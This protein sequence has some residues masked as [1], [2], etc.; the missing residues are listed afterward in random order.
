MSIQKSAQQLYQSSFNSLLGLILLYLSNIACV[1]N[2][3]VNWSPPIWNLILGSALEPNFFSRKRFYHQVRMFTSFWRYCLLSG[4]HDNWPITVFA[5]MLIS[6]KNDSWGRWSE[7]SV[8]EKL[9]MCPQVYNWRMS[10]PV[11]P[12]SP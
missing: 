10:I 5:L 11:T 8:V 4:I 1:S 12:S 9:L 7:I 6:F 2:F 3:L